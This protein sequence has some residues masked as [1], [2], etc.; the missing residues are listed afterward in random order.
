M[1]VPVR[2]FWNFFLA[3]DI[4][5]TQDVQTVTSC[6]GS[7]S[8]PASKDVLVMDAFEDK[9][10]AHFE[11]FVYLSWHDSATP[12]DDPSA[13]GHSSRRLIEELH[14]EE[15]RTCFLLNRQSLNSSVETP[16]LHL[17]QQLVQYASQ[18]FPVL[19]R[20]LRD[21]A[22]CVVFVAL[23]KDA[24]DTKELQQVLTAMLLFFLRSA[25]AMAPYD[26]LS[27][28]ARDCAQFFDYPRPEFLQHLVAYSVAHV[29][30]SATCV[31]VQCH[32]GASVL[33]VETAALSNARSSQHC[34]CSRSSSSSDCVC[35]HPFLVNDDN[36]VDFDEEE[37]YTVDK[38]FV[39]DGNEEQLVLPMETRARRGDEVRWV[40][41]DAVAVGRAEGS[42][43]S[44]TR[45]ERRLPVDGL[46]RSISSRFK[47]SRASKVAGEETSEEMQLVRGLQRCGKA[48]TDWS[49]SDK[50]ELYECELC[51]LP[52]CA[53]AEGKV[54][55]PMLHPHR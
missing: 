2:L 43:T 6:I 15:H 1:I 53:L 9:Y 27:Y 16:E 26:L 45:P 18:Y 11:H 34:T 42:T 46:N 49:S 40:A 17:F 33:T 31:M 41:V 22:G 35:F 28:F 36:G 19:Q 47:L 14:E 55:V 32:C 21:E 51:R 25:L 5:R 23:G 29:Q 37:F 38:M 13:H 50:W 4:T 8:E 52:I 12:P 20:R 48:I 24:E 44:W 54:A 10:E 7:G 30:D 39:H 3:A